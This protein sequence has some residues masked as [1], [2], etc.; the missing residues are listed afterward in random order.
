MG[1]FGKKKQEESFSE[2]SEENVLKEEL[3]SEVEKLQKWEQRN[4]V[5]A[6]MRR[7][8][9]EAGFSQSAKDFNLLDEGLDEDFKL[10]LD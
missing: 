8:R 10:E 7:Q 1:F 3:E 2:K 4:P 9:I 6:E 5:Q